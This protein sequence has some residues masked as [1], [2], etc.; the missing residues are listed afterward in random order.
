LRSTVHLLVPGITLFVV[1]FIGSVVVR[2]LPVLLFVGVLFYGSWVIPIALILTIAAFAI[3]Y[4]RR[5]WLSGLSLVCAAPLVFAVGVF[6]NPVNSP[7]GWAANV[8]KVVYYHNDLQ[9]SYAEAKN[10]GQASPLGQADVEGFGSLASG[11]VYDPSG[12]IALPP[13]R[14]S[15]AWTDG[16]GA[17]ELGIDALEVHHIFGPYYH[18]F[19]P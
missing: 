14:R 12:E 15:K 5:D 19:H 18:W 10:S 8:L 4:W 11:L 7:V 6:P 17:T 9:Q 16:P 13:N 1:L 3:F 2:S